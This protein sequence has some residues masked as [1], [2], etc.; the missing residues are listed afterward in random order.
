MTPVQQ[1]PA[2]PPPD[3]PPG[4]KKLLLAAAGCGITAATIL[5][6]EINWR[7]STPPP[8]PVVARAPQDFIGPVEPLG[9][10]L[11]LPIDEENEDARR[12]RTVRRSEMVE[13][14]RMADGRVPV[15]R[16][17]VEGT[18]RNLFAEAGLN[19][20]P[21]RLFLRAFKREQELEVWSASELGGFRLVATYEIARYSGVPGPKRREGDGQTPEGFYRIDRFN[22]KSSFHLSMGLNYPNASD[23]VLSDP[24]KPGYDIFIH[25][26]ASSIGCLA[27]GD[28]RIEELFITATDT[29]ERPINVHI[30]PARMNAPDWAEW[31]AEQTADRPDLLAF[32]ENLRPG[33]E[34]FEQR[35]LLPEVNVL[36]DG[37]YDF[38]GGGV[39]ASGDLRQ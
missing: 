8:D 3:Q 21:E 4:R 33:F 6:V 23:A 36:P 32:W 11:P 14:P 26:R 37:R 17:R 31:C 9:P 15:A 7:P 38:G 39:T 13:L 18:L 24:M 10:P 25:G 22:P 35:R 16:E 29:A 28:D 12:E 34:Y 2:P 20:P 5:I 30:F 27:M 19:Y 1:T